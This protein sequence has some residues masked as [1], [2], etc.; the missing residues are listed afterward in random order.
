[1]KVQDVAKDLG[2]RNVLEGSVRRSGNRL[3]ITVQ[4]ID[5]DTGNHLWA[6]RYD[7][8]LKDIFSVQ[9]QVTQKV[10]SELA[11][12]LKA[13]EMERLFRKHTANIEAYDLY[14]R[15]IRKCW[16]PKKE[17]HAGNFRPCNVASLLI[18][19]RDNLH[20]SLFPPYLLL[21]FYWKSLN[22]NFFQICHVFALDILFIGSIFFYQC[23]W[24][25][26]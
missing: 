20:T 5:A 4:L 10:V 3:R 24:K 19:H 15:I 9:D 1:M 18:A 16:P 26:G 7:R 12:T 11:V 17:C 21:C 13:S 22:S 8:E 23:R 14:V 2:V 6:E 25:P